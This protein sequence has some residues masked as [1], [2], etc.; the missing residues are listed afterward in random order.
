[1]GSLGFVLNTGVGH[2]DYIL[3]QQCHRGHS[4][5]VVIMTNNF[6]KFQHQQVQYSLNPYQRSRLDVYTDWGV[7]STIMCVC[8]CASHASRGPNRES[9]CASVPH[10][11]KLYVMVE[12][13]V[14]LFM[15]WLRDCGWISKLSLQSTDCPCSLRLY[16]IC[17]GFTK[18]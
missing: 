17:K 1:M 18:Y 14:L 10:G 4:Y 16:C 5:L 2:E 7:W 8:T 12:L 13:C 11:T 6:Y 9:S 15:W 3:V